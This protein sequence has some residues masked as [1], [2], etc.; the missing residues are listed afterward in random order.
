MQGRSRGPGR[1]NDPQAWIEDRWISGEF[2]VFVPWLAFLML[3]VYLVK[4]F[5]NHVE[6]D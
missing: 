2:D 4:N 5:L 3:K 1:Q 6:T